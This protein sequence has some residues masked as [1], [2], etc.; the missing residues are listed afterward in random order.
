MGRLNM[1]CRWFGVLVVATGLGLAPVF[2]QETAKTTT[3]MTR[4][5]VDDWVV[6]CLDP[7]ITANPCQVSHTV[8]FG[9]E[10]APVFVAAFAGDGPGSPLRNCL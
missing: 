2:G 3:D 6:E 8:L 9:P 10:S 7:P 5:N 4:V 1:S